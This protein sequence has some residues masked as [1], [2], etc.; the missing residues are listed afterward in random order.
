MSL[1]KGPRG[2][3]CEAFILQYVSKNNS[4]Q[5]KEIYNFVKQAGHWSERTVYLTIKNL[6]CNKSGGLVLTGDQ[7]CEVHSASKHGPKPAYHIL[8][9]VSLLQ[10][11]G[12]APSDPEFLDR[13]EKSHLKPIP[14]ASARKGFF[15]TVRAGLRVGSWHWNGERMEVSVEV[16]TLGQLRILADPPNEP[17]M[18]LGSIEVKDMSPEELD[19]FLRVKEYVLME[20]EFGLPGRRP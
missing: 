10:S 9:V 1:G 5:P 3:G 7:A 4:A 19:T 11:Q 13:T 18:V 8:H 6:L 16:P 20:G 12:I 17:E 15:V 2:S 14:G